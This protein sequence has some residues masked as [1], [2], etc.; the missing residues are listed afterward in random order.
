MTYEAA[1][2]RYERRN[3]LRSDDFKWGVCLPSN[4]TGLEVVFGLWH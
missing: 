1:A 4:A 2:G 3:A